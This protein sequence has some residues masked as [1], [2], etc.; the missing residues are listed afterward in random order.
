MNIPPEELQSN[1][2]RIKEIS[3]TA[4]ITSNK[5]V[6]EL[7]ELFNPKESIDLKVEKTENKEIEKTIVKK[8]KKKNISFSNKEETLTY[9]NIDI[10]KKAVALGAFFTREDALALKEKFPDDDIYIKNVKSEKSSYFVPYSVNIPKSKLTENLDRLRKTVPSAYVTSNKRVKELAELYNKNSLEEKIVKNESLN[11]SLNNKDIA[12]NT[13]LP[14]TTPEKEELPIKKEEKKAPL[15]FIEETKTNDYINRTKRSLT[16][17]KTKTLQKAKEIAKT[18]YKYDVLIKAPVI[19]N[20]DYTVYLINI[21]KENISKIKNEV[22]KIYPHTFETS[23]TRISYFYRKQQKSDIFINKNS[24]IP[25]KNNLKAIKRENSNITKNKND[26]QEAKDLF[27]DRNYKKALNL[28][29]EI[30]KEHPDDPN[31]NFYIGRSYYELEDYESASSYFE[32][33]TIK[34][35]NNLRAKL[36]LAQTYMKLELYND[37]VENFNTVLQSEIPNNVKKN[38][39]RR[40]AH[41][42]N[43]QKKHL[44]GGSFNF[45]ITHDNNSFNVSDTR[46]FN[47]LAFEGLEVTD[48]KYS[49]VSKTALLNLNHIYKISDRYNIKNRI[50]IMKKLYDKDDQR[51]NDPT[52]TGIAR[53]EKKELDLLSYALSLSKYSQN[54]AITGEIDISKTKVASKDYL[55]TAGLNLTYQRILFR[56]IRSMLSVKIYN[57]SYQQHEDMNLD[58]RNFQFMFGQ[59]LPTDNWGKFNLIY[60]YANEQKT[61]P[62]KNGY[63]SRTADERMDTLYLTNFYELTDKL[64]LQTGMMYSITKTKDA[65]STFDTFGIKRKDTLK[66]IF[67]QLQYSYNKDITLTT[68]LK[69]Y[70]TESNIDIYSYDKML[71]DFGFIYSF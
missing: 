63:D 47:T 30:S 23:R 58:S 33:I 32:R 41:I 2:N 10:S 60:I 51:L 34:D 15:Y 31:L 53:E 27:R 20:R 69:Y 16:I 29:L 13:D 18:L 62:L 43:K 26:Y 50:N 6:R 40:L 17:A 59:M 38:I 57:K 35:D 4:Y 24:F 25:V 39:E 36:E 7:A 56:K 61:S 21:D 5:R 52:A 14:K 8:E 65:D 66:S 1:L 3:P 70:D 45:N 68:A 22:K 46:T 71:I 64:S 19:K 49:E 42:E 28:F 37:A 54:D 67:T 12:I 11:S 9:G 44:F 55:K 48:E